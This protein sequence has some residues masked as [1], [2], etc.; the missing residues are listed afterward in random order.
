MVTQDEFE[1]WFERWV[2]KRVRDDEERAGMWHF[3]VNCAGWQL[4][5]IV[6]ER[7]GLAAVEEFWEFV[8]TRWRPVH[9]LPKEERYAQRGGT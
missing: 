2:T 8:Y 4:F 7:N 1:K 9:P 6:V 5:G 3:V